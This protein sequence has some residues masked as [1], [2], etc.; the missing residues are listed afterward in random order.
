MRFKWPTH[1]RALVCIFSCRRN[2][3]AGNG[4]AAFLRHGRKQV[5]RA[6][7]NDAWPCAFLYQVK[8]NQASS[9]DKAAIINA[10]HHCCGKSGEMMV[11]RN[12]AS[13]QQTVSSAG[14]AAPHGVTPMRARREI[15][16]CRKLPVGVA[17]GNES[18]YRRQS[19]KP[20]SAPS[21]MKAIYWR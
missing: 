15:C 16:S 11:R 5:C 1:H 12:G 21:A 19:P 3:S 7:A 14:V 17:R 10:R 8:K 2:T 6:G 4:I 18:S 13:S 20:I 9:I